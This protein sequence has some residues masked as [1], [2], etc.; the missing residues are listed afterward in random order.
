MRALELLGLFRRVP[1]GRPAADI[2]ADIRAE[3]EH[4]LA[5]AEEELVHQGRDREEARAEARRRFG[6]LD[7]IQRTCLEIQTWE[8][9]MLQRIHLAVTVF[10]LAAVVFLIWTNQRA[11]ATA[12][13]IA[14][15]ARA[16][17]EQRMLAALDALRRARSEP[18][19]HI[20]IGVGDVLEINDS[21]NQELCV[22]EKVAADGKV[23]LPDAGWVHVAGLT[24][25]EAEQLLTEAC[26]P[27]FVEVD[28]KVK[29]T[30]AAEQAFEDERF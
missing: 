17:A 23:L 15:A 26:R 7:A 30:E 4:H 18:V 21:Y 29:V 19:E 22:T 14:Q 25:Q 12:R 5:C 13:E 10:L 2:A 27:Y 28:I 11:T 20:V 3:L 16:E 24:R 8:R 1:G 9:I 6:D